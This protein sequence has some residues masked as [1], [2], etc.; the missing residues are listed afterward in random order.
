MPDGSNA[1]ATIFHA[2]ELHPGMG[3]AVAERTILRRK[4]DGSFETWGDVAARVA[5]GNALLCPPNSIRPYIAERAFLQK[6]IGKATLLMSGR[7]LQHGD[8]TQPHRNMEVFTNC[9]TAP[10][11]SLLFLLLLNGS[12]VGRAYDD[13]MALIDWNNAPNLRLVIDTGHPDFDWS[14][15][16]DVRSARHKYAGE[17]VRWHTVEDSREGWAKAVEVWET[18]AY[19]KVYRDHTLVLDFSQVRCKGS[20]IGGMQGRPASGPKPLMDALRKCATIKGAG[21]KPWMQALYIDHYLAECVLVGGARRAAR[22]ATKWWRDRNIIDF[23]RVKRPIE[24]A[25]MTMGEVVDYRRELTEAKR[26]PP[27]AFL[28]SSN[29]SVTVDDEF[30][31]LVKQARALVQSGDERHMTKLQA[32]AWEVITAICESSY[33]DGTGEPGL[34]NVQKLRQN[35]T[36][37]RGLEDGNFVGSKKYQVDDETRLVLAR[38]AKVAGKKR[39]HQITNPCGEISLSLLGAYCVI[40][41]LVPFHADTLDEAEE[42]F[43]V[44]TRALMRVNLMDSLYKREVARTNRIGV[45]IT[46]VHEF[47]W[48]FFRVGFRDLVNPD[49]IEFEDMEHTVETAAASD[50][51]GLRSAA[52]WLTLARFSRAVQD[53]AKTYA[54]EL[55]VAVPHTVTT[56]KPAGTTSKLFGLTEG[57]HLPAMAQYLRWV[58][59]RNDDPLVANYVKAGYPTR[60]LKTYSG[61]TIIGFPTQPTI[62]ALGMGDALVTAAEAT[63]EEQYR[64]L[65]L[66]E[67]FWIV[68][69]DEAGN[70]LHPEGE[71]LGNQISYT[72]KYDPAI[73]DF[74]EFTDMLIEHQSQIRCCSVLPVA[75][76]SAY[77]YVPEQAISKAEYES[78]AR[79]VVEAGTLKEEIGFEHVDCGAGACPVDFQEGEKAP[80]AESLTVDSQERA[81]PVLVISGETGR[82]FHVYGYNDGSCPWCD[83]A[84]VLIQ[85]RGHGLWFYDIKEQPW[86]DRFF[87]ERSDVPRTVPQVYEWTPEGEV[88]VGGYT[89]LTKYLGVMPE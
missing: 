18:M 23:I 41:D 86:K 44:A 72:L 78:L 32:H 64:W 39:Y 50:D 36:G 76:T 70:S 28:W 22:M 25:G 46:G 56:I 11:S 58:Q 3:Q 16:E 34:I 62:G 8:E 17:T 82:T 85:S 88:Y 15:D 10:L 73:V 5:D 6:H 51:G 30:W 63:P 65:Q 68:G 7:H 52:F 74:E 27:F 75:D 45:G 87:A 19:Q 61:T 66:G 81:Q 84:K 42:A 54:A 37:W 69:T 89:D 59:F 47:A 43:R 26:T 53:E 24:Y 12:G 4:A 2:R 77:E 48:K 57:W 38:L 67:K 31:I 33:G 80:A 35:D 21:M 13:D 29:N 55:G 14:A 1:I 60:Q 49:F 9:S 83:Q 40:A 79:A 20:P 71:D